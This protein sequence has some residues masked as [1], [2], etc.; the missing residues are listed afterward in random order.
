M[1][2]F[3]HT[4]SAVTLISHGFVD[5]RTPF[6][7]GIRKPL[8]RNKTLIEKDPGNAGHILAIEY[9]FMAIFDKE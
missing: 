6:P 1:L 4:M 9:V 2:G 8:R 3:H 7:A 5:N